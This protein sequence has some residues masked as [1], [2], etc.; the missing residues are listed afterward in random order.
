M[1]NRNIIIANA[2]Q[3]VTCSGCKAK[4]G[5]EM[6]DLHLIENGTVIIEN[7]R[8]KAAVRTQELPD[9]FDTQGFTVI[10]ASGKTVLPGFTDP[11][12]HFVF[13]GYRAEEFCRRL[14]GES[15]LSIMERG[16]GIMN[17]VR[18][19]R[20][21][22]AEELMRFGKKRLDAM[23]SFGVTT[24]EGKSGYGLD[25][26]S[27]IRQLEVMRSLNE[28]HPVDIVPTFLGAHAIPP[29]YKGKED[30]FIA[31]MTEEVMPE[32]AQRDLAEF[33]DIF[34]E[35]NVFSVPMSRKYLT[36]A[37]ELGFCLTLH[38]D[39][40]A[41]LGGAEL[42]AELKAVSAA[43]LLRASDQGIADMAAAG[44]VAVLLP[45]TAFSLKEPYAKAR[46]MIDQ[47]CAAALA[48]DMNP[49]SCFTESVPLIFALAVLHMGMSI[50]EAVTAFTINAAAAVGRAD[51]S[52]SIDPGK[53]GDILILEYPSY[54]FIP[55]H[56]A[57]NTVE[58]VIKDGRIVFDRKGGKLC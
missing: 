15:Y 21:A 58:T 35:K 17:T 42:A 51:S 6:S 43:H 14:K 16:G 18:A 53:K 20:K 27:E 36:R 13:A 8:I 25:R 41:P 23:L 7:G 4:A 39:E 32:I 12:T 47:G 11:H 52:G 10:D 5:R 49:G 34:C 28:S 46:H 50:E 9:G 55:Y 38:A 57:V 56:L 24:V 33:C 2:A 45:G 37:K 54:K 22:S 26:E 3:V 19:T 29:E 1:E 48:T 30:D 44:V 40:I 31:W